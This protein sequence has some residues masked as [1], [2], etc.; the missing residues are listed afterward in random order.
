M[1]IALANAL[2]ELKMPLECIDT[3]DEVV[4]FDDLS[5]LSEQSKIKGIVME[6]GSMTSPDLLQF[7]EGFPS[8]KVLM[9]LKEKDEFFKKACIS[10]SITTFST[11]L[12]NQPD[13]VKRFIEYQWLELPEDEECNNVIAVCGTHPQVGVTQTVWTLAKTMTEYN[14]RV[15]VVGLNPYNPG[16]ISTQDTVQSLD[17]VYPLLEN[18]LVSDADQIKKFM[19]RIEGFHYLVGNRDYYRA[20]SYKKEPIEYLINLLKDHFDIV[21]LDMGAFYDSFLA[22]A[23]LTLADTHILVASQEVVAIKEYKRWKEQFIDAFGI[24]PKSRYLIVNKYG[25]KATITPRQLEQDLGFPWLGH[26]PYFPIA[27]DVEI[28]EGLLANALDKPYLK[29]STSLVKALLNEVND[30]KVER[31]RKSSVFATIFSLFH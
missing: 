20:L 10:H 3:I 6:R 16:E 18:Q 5:S 14:R 12:R 24:T 17:Q 13:Q 28:N 23:G 25:S 31:K 1:K 7:R 8:T 15:A 19:N 27:N 22:V 9:F 26:L 11:E 2:S 29:A 4:L 21:L 30:F